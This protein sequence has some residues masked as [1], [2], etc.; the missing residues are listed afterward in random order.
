MSEGKEWV[1]TRTIT[2]SEATMSEILDQ[3]DEL[4]ERVRVAQAWALS[5]IE[6][7]RREEAK[8]AAATTSA[9]S[10][11]M[12]EAATERRALQAMLKMLQAAE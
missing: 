11:V 5:R 12:V 9:K 8:F 10:S 2:V 6:H 3:R 7:C 4:R 1:M